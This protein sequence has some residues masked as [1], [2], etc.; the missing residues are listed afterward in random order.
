MELAGRA[1]RLG[2]RLT[3]VMTRWQALRNWSGTNLSHVFWVA[4]VDSFRGERCEGGVKAGLRK[5]WCGANRA[6]NGHQPLPHIRF[7][8][9]AIAQTG[10]GTA[11]DRETAHP[12]KVS[13]S[14]QT[15]TQRILGAAWRISADTT[16]RQSNWP[17][18]QTLPRLMGLHGRRR[19]ERG[20]SPRF[21]KDD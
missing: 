17:R 8:T 15:C 4:E 5:L 1:A 11:S 19:S 3:I 16:V 6:E 14:H 10:M 7:T 2:H 20:D 18:R 9:E 13:I 12:G 21:G